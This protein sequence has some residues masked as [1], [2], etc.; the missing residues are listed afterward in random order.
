MRS[1]LFIT[2]RIILGL[3]LVWIGF[4]QFG[5]IDNLKKFVPNT[6]EIIEK[7]LLQPSNYNINLESLK[8]NAKEILLLDYFL[9]IVSGIM[10]IFGLRIGKF[11][12]TLSLMID[13]IFI[14]NI[15]VYTDEKFL[16]NASRFITILGGSFYF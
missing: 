1:E 7:K 5:D 6:I 16:L 8:K 14:H 12:L 10:I 9:I 2:L 11:L 15:G 13:F 4:K 3:Y